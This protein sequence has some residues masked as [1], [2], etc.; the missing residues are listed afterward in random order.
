MLSRILA[1]VA[2]LTMGSTVL[3]AY[4]TVGVDPLPIPRT[5]RCAADG[6]LNLPHLA[7]CTEAGRG[8]LVKLLR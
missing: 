6:R 8:Y 7:P 2:A 3:V 4:H 1:A 5:E